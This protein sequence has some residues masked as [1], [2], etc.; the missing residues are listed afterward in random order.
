M[1]DPPVQGPNLRVGS[2]STSS[3]IFPI[4]CNSTFEKCAGLADRKVRF[5]IFSKNYS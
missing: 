3:C 5:R 1:T 2:M 4:G